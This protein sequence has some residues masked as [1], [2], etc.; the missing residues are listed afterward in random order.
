M[1]QLSSSEDQ[2]GPGADPERLEHRCGLQSRG[3]LAVWMATSAA[4]AVRTAQHVKTRPACVR[5]RT[6]FVCGAGCVLASCVSVSRSRLCSESERSDVAWL[7]LGR[8]P[9]HGSCSWLRCRV[10]GLRCGACGVCDR[11]RAAIISGIGAHGG[12]ADCGGPR[13]WAGQ[14]CPAHPLHRYATTWAKANW[15]GKFLKL[16]LSSK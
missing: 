12:G 5:A 10:C 14:G 8:G 11:G 9:G 15:D 2:K 6:M 13:G 1:G 4:S 16:E 3:E 7:V